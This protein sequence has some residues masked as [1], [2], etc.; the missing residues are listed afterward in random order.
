MKI[1][2]S[3]AE[4]QQTAF[5]L[6]RTGKRIAFVPT[7]GFLHEGHASLL[8]EGRKQG[9]VLVLSI[10]VNPIQFGAGEDLDRYPR[11]LEGDRGIAAK[12]CAGFKIPP[13]AARKFHYHGSTGTQ[14]VR[15]PAP[16]ETTPVQSGSARKAVVGSPLVGEPEAG[17]DCPQPPAENR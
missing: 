12:C 9:D 17:D 16:V 5:S 3:I 2:S 14:E 1:I 13:P 7:M 4:M 11:H 8:R 6:K 10:F 15:A